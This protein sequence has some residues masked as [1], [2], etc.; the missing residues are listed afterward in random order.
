MNNQ[1]GC[2]QNGSPGDPTPCVCYNNTYPAGKS[3]SACKAQCQAM[4]DVT[5]TSYAYSDGS[6][7]GWSDQCCIWSDG[8]WEPTPQVAHVSGRWQGSRPAINVWKAPVPGNFPIEQLR[9]GGKR[10]PRARHPNADPETDLWPVGY[11]P[12]AEQ[13][14]QPPANHQQPQFVLVNNSALAERG[15]TTFNQY[16]G[17]IGGPCAVFDPPFS[18][19]CSEHPSG[20]GGFQ[21]F[22]PRGLIFPN[23]SLP[24]MPWE[25]KG[26]GA[27][28]H[29][30]RRSHWANWMFEVADYDA[31]SMSLPL[32][33]P[34]G[35]TMKPLQSL[36]RCTETALA[37]LCAVS[38]TSML[39]RVC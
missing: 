7:H 12:N 17:G 16:S 39:L 19:W 32:C 37:E 13:W 25:K 18:Y 34:G 27:V 36:P 20:G 30:W 26:V 15:S 31:V 6:N 22:V 9:I 10:A 24:D 23:G 38:V 2:K 5:C 21:Y 3:A 8:T 1:H 35:L 4:G 14:L 11:I 29:V 33:D 28:A